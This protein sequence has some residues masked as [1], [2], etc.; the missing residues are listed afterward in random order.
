MLFLSLRLWRAYKLRRKGLRPLPGPVG[1]PLLGNI[2]DVPLV[3]GHLAYDQMSKRFARQPGPIFQ[4]QI[5]NKRFIMVT[6]TAVAIELLDKRGANYSDRPEFPILDLA[7]WSWAT[8]FMKQNDAWRARRRLLHQ[9]FNATGTAKV[10]TI[11]RRATLELALSLIRAPDA[12]RDH[13][14]RQADIAAASILRTVYGFDIALDDDPYVAIADKAVESLGMLIPGTNLV[15]WMPFLRH[16]PEW[17]PGAPKARG[18]VLRQYPDAMLEK[19]YAQAM[20]DLREGRGRQCMLT[21]DLELD[22][23]KLDG[24]AVKEAAAVAY[25]GGADT[26][27]STVVAFI[28][29]MVRNTGVQKKAQEELD[30][31][32]GPDRLPEFADREALPYIEAIIRET[33]RKYPVGPIG[34][35]HTAQEEDEFEG[36]EITK[37]ALILPVV[38]TMM[39]NEDAYGLEPEHFNPER[40]LENG[41]INPDMQ[42]PRVNLFGFGRR[43]CPGLHFAD[44][45]VFIQVATM[46]KCFDF[47]RAVEGGV[48]VIPPEK[49]IPGIVVAP[50]PFKCTIKPRSRH[51]VA[52]L[53]QAYE[54]SN[55]EYQAEP[56]QGQRGRGIHDDRGHTGGVHAQTCRES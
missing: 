25:L 18:R 7:G 48:E 24:N 23:R 35:P 31:V 10:H 42:D 38:W 1:V 53:N 26:T 55:E 14:R 5:S 6:S 4:L 32:I 50:A 45:N 29:A 8:V 12:Y 2:F 9:R 44:A 28:F 17:V 34:I 11:V 13:V 46:L 43:K 16:I 37:G 51:V 36:M 27:V 19:P 30:R 39:H 54:Q 56:G 40:F 52:L 22:D 41:A 33:Y 20:E 15:D 47:G 3:D 21:E 49:F